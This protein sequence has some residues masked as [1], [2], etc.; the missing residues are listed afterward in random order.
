MT[1]LVHLVLILAVVAGTLMLPHAA[2]AC[3]TSAGAVHPMVM[4][5]VDDTGSI[6]ADE[7]CPSVHSAVA[8]ELMRAHAGCMHAVCNVAA[9]PWQTLQLAATRSSVTTPYMPVFTERVGAV[10]L[11]D[12]G[13]HLEVADWRAY[14]RLGRQALPLRI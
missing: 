1:R 4:V 13:F 2:M 8:A 14:S 12:R 7:H 10:S 5:Q 3:C 11:P 9:A 6:A